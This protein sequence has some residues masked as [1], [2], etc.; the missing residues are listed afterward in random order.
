[1]AEVK[2]VLVEVFNTY[3]KMSGKELIEQR[4]T[5]DTLELRNDLVEEFSWEDE[6][7]TGSF[8]KGEE[9]IVYID[10]VGGDWDKPTGREIVI[11]TREDK[12]KELEN[13]YNSEIRFINSLFGVEE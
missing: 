11:S 1:M 12:L 8:L 6:W 13:K 3:G 10:L 5:L 7:G 2:E 9:D 4:V